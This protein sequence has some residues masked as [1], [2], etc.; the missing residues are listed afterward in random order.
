MNLNTWKKIVGFKRIKINTC[1][2]KNVSDLLKCLT[3][4]FIILDGL[5]DTKKIF[6]FQYYEGDTFG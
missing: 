1:Y 2:K 4:R 3:K 6:N 5:S